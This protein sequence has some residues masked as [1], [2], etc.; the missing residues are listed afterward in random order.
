MSSM[1]KFLSPTMIS[2]EQWPDGDKGYVI[3][4]LEIATKEPVGVKVELTV[5]GPDYQVFIHRS[6]EGNCV[7]PTM[8]TGFPDPN[9]AHQVRDALVRAFEG[10]IELKVVG[11]LRAQ[12]TWKWLERK[13]RPDQS[14]PM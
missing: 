13:G 6:P 5:S 9:I 11:P 7:S 4:G 10:R 8:L 14:Q 12:R 1:M 3:V 2:L